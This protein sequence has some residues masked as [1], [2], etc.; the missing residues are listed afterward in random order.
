MDMSQ[1]T[2]ENLSKNSVKITIAVA[3]EEMQPMLE[4]AAAE[5]SEQTTIEGFR[6]GKAPYDVVKNRVGEMKIYEAALQDIVRKSYIEAVDANNLEVAGE[7][8]IKVEKMVPGS[9][10]EYTVEVSLMPKITKLADWKTMFVEKKES[11]VADKDI[12]QA[13]KDLQRMQTKEIREDKD[14]VATKDHKAVINMNIKKDGVPIEGGQATN[15][16]VYLCEDHYIPG[17]CD[18]IIGMKEGDQKTFVLKFPDTHFQKTVAGKDVEFDV[19]MNELYRLDHPEIDDK[20]AAA[21]GQKDLA[22]L[23][24]IIKDNLQLEKDREEAMRQ[25]RAM[26]EAISNKTEFEEIAEALINEEVHKMIHEIQHNVEQQGGVFEDYLKSINKTLGEMKLGFTPEA[27]VRI[28]VALVIREIAKQEG[29]EVAENEVDA[30][31]DKLAE[32]YEDK[33]AKKQIYTPANREYMTAML[34][35]RKVI[36]LLKETMVKSK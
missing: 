13:L 28:K 9:D 22:G 16:T 34:K 2:I 35:N 25:E 7:P 27:L 1:S 24:G 6:P 26:L 10:L 32:R 3:V 11:T 30:E 17:F 19:T 15:N 4:K 8:N 14:K 12:N 31:L 5:L 20:L 36:D 21:L 29:I 23:K 18:E 33:E